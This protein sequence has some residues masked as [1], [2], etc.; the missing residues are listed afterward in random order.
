MREEARSFANP[1]NFSSG[2]QLF[3]VCG[4][5]TLISMLANIA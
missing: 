5:D 3:G 4:M 2:W 1:Q